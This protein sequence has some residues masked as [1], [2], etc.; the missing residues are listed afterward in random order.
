MW[1]ENL[2]Y[3]PLGLLPGYACFENRGEGLRYHAEL[4]NGSSIFLGTRRFPLWFGL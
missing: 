1:N 2:G 4:I 3:G